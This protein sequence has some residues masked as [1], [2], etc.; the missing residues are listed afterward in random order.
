[1]GITINYANKIVVVVGGTS[2]INR[3]VAEAFARAGAKV[4]VASRSQEKVADTIAALQK[5]GA[6]D[7]MGFVAD[8]R[9]PESVK[10]GMAEIYEAWG[11]F[12]LVISG[13]A[14]NFPALAMEDR[15]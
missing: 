9:E 1:M 6:A 8:V 15:K 4:A 7:A 14:C 13:A 5:Q 12:D 2:G 10:Q 3:G 11:E